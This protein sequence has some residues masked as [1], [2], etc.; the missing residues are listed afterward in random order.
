MKPEINQTNSDSFREN[1]LYSSIFNPCLC[2]IAF[3]AKGE[4]EMKNTTKTSKLIK[5]KP[6][7]LFAISNNLQRHIFV[8]TV[9]IGLIFGLI[10]QTVF[11]Q[12][13]P[14][15]NV[16]RGIANGA[17]FSTS[18]IETIN[19]TNGNLML[20]IPLA[21]LP[22]GRGDIS[23]SL[24]LRYNSK[25]MET[26]IN[27]LMDITNQ[28]TPQRHLLPSDEAGWHYV[29]SSSYLLDITNRP[30]AESNLCSA[31]DV[32]KRDYTWK[33]EMI[34][35]DGNKVLF[36]P[37]GYTDYY[38][39]N[40]FR[41]S[42]N[43]YQ[44]T[45][46][47][48]NETSYD[49]ITQTYST[50]IN[51]SNTVTNQVTTQPMT[52][53]SIDGSYLKLVIDH[54]SNP[55]NQDGRFNPWTLYFPDGR[56]IT[57]G[58]N[59]S[60]KHY[61][62]NGNFVEGLTDNFGRSIQ[63]LQG[64]NADEDIIRVK[65]V[66]GEDIDVKVRWKYVHVRKTYQTEA[67]TSDN[68]RGNHSVQNHVGEYRVIDEIELPPQTGGQ[69][70]I[71]GYNGNSAVVPAGQESIGWGELN[72]ITLPSGAI[73]TYEYDYNIL[74][75][76]T[77]RLKDV[78][79]HSIKKKTL[80]YNLEYDGVMTPT[81][82][83][84]QYDIGRGGATV[85]SPD[86]SSSAQSHGDTSY[87]HLYNGL[88]F[89]VEN[90]NGTKVEK[91][92]DFNWSPWSN[93]VQTNP[94]VKA[95]FSSI[96]DSSGNYALTVIKEF[97]H[98]KNGNVT[99]VKEYD[100]VPYGSV[101]RD[102]GGR[103]TG[104]PGGV[105][106]A[107]MS[108]TDYYNPTPDS[109]DTSNSPNAYWNLN[110]PNIK[111]LA[112]STETLNGSGQVFSRS[113]M[114]F[115]N[116]STT[117]NLIESKTWDSS[118]GAYSNPL[119]A[120]NSVSTSTQYNQYGMPVLTTDIK[121]V[122]TQITYEQVGSV[123][124]LYP[125]MVKTAFGLPEQRTATT[126]YDFQTGL[127]TSTTDV[128]FG[129]TNETIYDPI[130]R[131]LISKAAINTPH[132]IWTQ[133]EYNDTLRRVIVKSDLFAKGDGKKVGIQHFD[134]L[135]RVRLSRTLEDA[136][137]QNPY[138][139]ADGVK[140]QTRYRYDNG[141]NPANSNGTFS[142]T[143]NPYRTGNETE[144]GWTVAYTDKTG[145]TSTVKTY[146]GGS[147]PA[148]WGSN[149]NLTGI[150]SSQIE[151]NV[152]IG[153]DQAGKQGRSIT[154]GLGQLVRVDEPD[155]NGNLGSISNPTQPTFYNYNTLGQMVKVEQGVQSRYFLYDNLGRLLRVRQPEQDVNAN[156][157]LADPITGN[158]QWTAAFTYDISGNLLTATDAKNV[159]ITNTYDILNR[160]LTRSYSDGTPT[161]TYSYDNSSVPYSK[162]KLTQVTNSVSTSQ[163]LAFDNLGRVLASRQIT[164]GTNYDSSYLYNLSGALVEET[165]P[166][167]R[168]VKNSFEVDGDLSK[169]ETQQANNAWEMRANN[170]AY[171]PSGAISQIQIGNGLWETA[172]FNNRLQVT[173]LGLG[174]SMSDTSIW[175][176]NYEFGEL[177]ANGNV[178][179]SKN[180]GNI[181]KQTVTSPAGTFT[182]SF[183]YDSLERLKEAKETSGG[184]QTWI[185]NF[186][187]DRYGNRVGFN[188]TINGQTSNGTPSVD[189][190]TN[191][192]TTGQGYVYD[193]AGN[194][195]QDP[196]NR[197]FI[198]NGDN[199]QVQVKDANQNVIGTYF[200]DADGKRIKKVTNSENT[201]F[202]YSGGK[203]VAEYSVTNS[204]PT[205]PTTQYTAT[206]MLG[207]PRVITN[208]SA[209]VVSRRDFMPFG[210]DLS[211]PNYGT[212]NLRQKFT[213]YEKDNETG[214][215]FAEARYYNNSVGRFTAVDPLLASGKSA[216]P[217]TFNR[218]IY[219]LNSPL[220][221]S[222]PSGM[223][224]G[225]VVAWIHQTAYNVSWAYNRQTGG[226]DRKVVENYN[227]QSDPKLAG[228]RN[229][230]NIS[231]STP[232]P[233]AVGGTVYNGFASTVNA[234]NYGANYVDGYHFTGKPTNT[235]GYLPYY[236][237]SSQQEGNIAEFTTNTINATSIMFG[238]A[239]L[240]GAFKPTP[241]FKFSPSSVEMMHPTELKF[242]EPFNRGVWSKH[243]SDAAAN[244]LKTPIE[245]VTIGCEN[246]VVCGNN[247]LGWAY[248]FKFEQVPVKKVE[249]PHLDFKTEFDVIESFIPNHVQFRSPVYKKYELK[250][251]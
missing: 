155:D 11:A 4:N 18:D 87:N 77:P 188:Q 220:K 34:M 170:F 144:M 167:G 160:M 124:D 72:S 151:A 197:Q 224:A 161:A 168:K 141:A 7:Q 240:S 69:K 191:R 100:F 143:S 95:E 107:R 25:L 43:G 40:H 218:Y 173:Q 59:V 154:N 182:Q 247:R 139:E 205:T 225:D 202:V 244:G 230:E 85:I 45:T 63:K 186:S 105:S 75:G 242:T 210:E 183:R 195:V 177:D 2:N 180:N 91:L 31:E 246:F 219:S 29:N 217:Q 229:S 207:S 116:P 184:N 99:Q 48:T 209:Q 35:P 135:G 241:S 132:E 136:T 201:T 23:Q 140:V 148:P 9:L 57:G 64:A 165:Y 8:F 19:L 33:V 49:W 226:V 199:K 37:T 223:Q 56:K 123:T 193:F 158:S 44:T 94:F 236:Q 55:Q 131:P 90:T 232:I 196:Q 129:L 245:Y 234:I 82:E 38:V 149:S 181:A 251:Q 53:Y 163:V 106:P 126:N 222:D 22:K 192:F 36:R 172:N 108:N 51:C 125:T 84:W 15:A 133:T 228:L 111:G 68:T 243:A 157:N 175:K 46:S 67:V 1:I 60:T 70:Y 239:N 178:N 102:S 92:W 61:D 179:Q 221:L 13:E 238:G 109:S 42:P 159:T 127:V 130:G 169:I 227:W 174:T 153:T 134:Q 6:L 194:V 32:W 198:F 147:L 27:D 89:A 21:G 66:D 14:P 101:P 166:S 113:E 62:R 24:N 204:T 200:Y 12:Y 214:L 74:P 119:N 110:S 17:S 208:Q 231:R 142:L 97:S 152:T 30:E 137:A 10:S 117:G 164:D 114:V 189:V 235:F 103:P 76:A 216:N 146:G 128:D 115:D 93:G 118:K 104:V 16:R 54:D 248:K 96:K 162:G 39:D 80:S 156:L 86:G 52:Y 98:D 73:V 26:W 5:N 65:G 78:L 81:S 203:L 58:T 213:G 71:F 138:N 187:Y 88:V 237:P 122:Q 233:I 120:G 121:G 206:D 50:T 212:D 112:A 41:V 28:V 190:S 150:T 215:D 250:D 47:L 83:V 145:K 3:R 171:N 211:R 176:L 249:L 185:Q 79:G 20:N